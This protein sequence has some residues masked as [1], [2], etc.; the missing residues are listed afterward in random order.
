MD[1]AP[2][3]A[4]EAPKPDAAAAPDAGA[5]AAP[6]AG[7][8]PA[9]PQKPERTFT[10]AELDEIVEKRL[11]KER[12]KREEIRREADVLRKLALQRAEAEAPRQP[13]PEAQ[14]PQG[15]PTR[16]Q[17]GSYEEFME[18]RAA[19]RG[20]K[21]ADARIK[22]DREERDRQRQAEEQ[23]KAGE[24]FRKRVKETA[25]DLPDFDEVL[26]NITA[27]SPVSHV[28]AEPIAN[29][30]NPGKL[31]YHLAT[32][33]EEAERIASLPLGQQAREVWKLEQKLSAAAPATKPSAAPEPIK[34]V[35]GRATPGDEMPDPAKNPE[36]WVKWRQQQIAASKRP[37][38]R[39]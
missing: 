15:E 34:P 18:A 24:D 23:K 9:E 17:F 8:P 27:E 32:H 2:A 39:A 36:K 19:W 1:T 26:S 16:E 31:L 25:K 35:G 22:Q 10:Q 7:A 29:S 20:E 30:D 3:T 38:A 28:A 4:P 13:P 12:K 21:A 6:E 11:S 33:P 37:V 5:A 14:K